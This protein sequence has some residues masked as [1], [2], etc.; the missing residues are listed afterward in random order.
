[1]AAY[2]DRDPSRV[3]HLT[4]WVSRFGGR[5][6]REITDDDVFLALEDI[7]SGESLYYA[8]KDSSGQPIYRSRG[9][10]KPATINRYHACLG[11]VFTFA[12]PHRLKGALDRPTLA[13]LSHLVHLAERHEGRDLRPTVRGRRTSSRLT[14][15]RDGGCRVPPGGHRVGRADASVEGV[16]GIEQGLAAFR[17]RPSDEATENRVLCT[18]TLSL[19]GLL[20]PRFR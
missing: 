7:A 10:H 11:A 16:G 5:P 20:Y 13:E 4:W 6:A 15:R 1:M 18:V 2:S 19:V 3:N 17:G 9:K 8:G 14:V 12:A